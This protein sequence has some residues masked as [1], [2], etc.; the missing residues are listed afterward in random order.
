MS[1]LSQTMMD[2]LTTARETSVGLTPVTG[3]ARTIAALK[4]RGLV[5]DDGL[6]LT[7][8]GAAVRAELLGEPGD[9]NPMSV[10]EVTPDPVDLGS[11]KVGDR[12]SYVYDGDILSHADLPDGTVGTVVG[13]LPD[14]PFSPIHVDFGVVDGEDYTLT[15]VSAGEIVPATP[16]PILAG[17]ERPS[18]EDREMVDALKASGVLVD[19]PKGGEF[20]TVPTVFVVPNRKDRRSLRKVAASLSR[21]TQRR[22]ARLARKHGHRHAAMIMAAPKAQSAA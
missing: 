11:F 6:F 16:T 17:I 4:T 1:K 19:K 18:D 3:A 12:V 10:P 21:A 20:T 13:F 7:K 9:V 8:A 2:V 22:F 5:T 14:C 15:P